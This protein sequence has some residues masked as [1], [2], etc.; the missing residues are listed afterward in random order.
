[1][2]EKLC[3]EDYEEVCMGKNVKKQCKKDKNQ[4]TK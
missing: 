3:S 2:H 4:D 1:M